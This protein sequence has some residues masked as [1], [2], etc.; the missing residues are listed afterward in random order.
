M[1]IVILLSG[2]QFSF[3]KYLGKHNP[4][5]SVNFH[6]EHDFFFF[7]MDHVLLI[8]QICWHFVLGIYFLN[9][10]KTPCY[11]DISQFFSKTL[12]LL[13]SQPIE[14]ALRQIFLNSL[15]CN[16]LDKRTISP[17]YVLC[18]F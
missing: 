10:S 17:D 5:F 1:K 9:D 7:K 8:F 16:I 18:V 6:S 13:R 11:Q 3:L 12:M 4:Y 2:Y 15:L 14:S